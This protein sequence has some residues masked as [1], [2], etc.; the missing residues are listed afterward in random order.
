MFLT[1]LVFMWLVFQIKGCL[2]VIE[3]LSKMGFMLLVNLNPHG[4]QMSH[5]PFS[6]S[7]LI[8]AYSSH[9]TFVFSH[10]TMDLLSTPSLVQ[11]MDHTLAPL[12][13]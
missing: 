12:L 2:V 7:C 5:V 4:H 11:T 9:H 8:E 3:N 10:T 1:C 6:S 13:F